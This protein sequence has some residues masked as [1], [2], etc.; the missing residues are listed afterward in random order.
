MACRDPVN[1]DGEE[2]VWVMD[3]ADRNWSNGIIYPVISI[4]QDSR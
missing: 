4:K 3:Q 2:I 1:S